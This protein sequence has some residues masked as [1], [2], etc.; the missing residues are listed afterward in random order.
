M[1]SPCPREP[2]A[3]SVK[4]NLRVRCPLQTA[5]ELPEGL[6]VVKGELS[7]SRSHGVKQGR[8]MPLPVLLSSD[9][10]SP[11]SGS[12]GLAE[13]V[14]LV[15]FHAVAID[16]ALDLALGRHLSLG[17]V[18]GPKPVSCCRCIPPPLAFHKSLLDL[19]KCVLNSGRSPWRRSRRA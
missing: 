4:G 15:L 2:V 18:L 3:A 19:L 8:G 14:V 13:D 11:P 17:S 12:P 10:R 5:C 1:E 7:G 16:A 9:L 6:H